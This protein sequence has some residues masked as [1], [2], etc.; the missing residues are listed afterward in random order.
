MTMTA[1]ENDSRGDSV[2][3]QETRGE[4]WVGFLE[5]VSLA[6]IKMPYSSK[7]EAVGEGSLGGPGWNT[8][9]KGHRDETSQEAGTV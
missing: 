3:C 4:I 2:G 6:V 8:G 5:D 9:F 1:C 7:V